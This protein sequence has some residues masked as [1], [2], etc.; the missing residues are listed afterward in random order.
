M[1][2]NTVID[3]P[4][5]DWFVESVATFG[6]R[7][8]AAREAAG[9]TQKSLAAKLGVRDSTV[10]A[11]E[12]DQSEPRSNRMQMLAGMLNVSLGWLMAGVGEGISAPANPDDDA[13]ALAATLDD[14]T[15]LKWQMQALNDTVARV[16]RR[17]GAQMDEAAE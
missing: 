7:L 5:T 11:W 17:I 4:E 2:I 13:R 10:K 14:M 16:E 1:A 3:T 6:D 8:E 15:R 12:D 9:L